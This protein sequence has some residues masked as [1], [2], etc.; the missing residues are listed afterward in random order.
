MTEHVIPQSDY[1]YDIET[2]KHVFMAEFQH[3]ATGQRYV[4]EVSRRRNDTIAFIQFIGF[5][6]E[7]RARTFGYNN[8]E[9]DYVVIH[10]LYEEFQKYGT[11][12]PLAAYD[13]AQEII[14][15]KAHAVAHFLVKQCGY[16]LWSAHDAAIYLLDQDKKQI[17]GIMEQAGYGQ[18]GAQLYTFIDTYE[19]PRFRPKIW[20]DNRLFIQGDLYKIHHFDNKA[21]RT[22]L[23]QL[24]VS[25][26]SRTVVDLPYSPHADLTDEQ[27]DELLQYMGHDV[28]ETIKFYHFSASQIATRDQLAE[29]YP[30]LGDVLNFNDTKIG[31]KFFELELEKASPGICYARDGGRRKPRQT[32]RPTIRLAEIISPKVE[33][34]HPNMRYTLDFFRG[35]ILTSDEVSTEDGGEASAQTKGFF[36]KFDTVVWPDGSTSISDTLTKEQKAEVAERGGKRLSSSTGKGKVSAVMDGF[37]FDFGTGGIHGSLHTTSVYEDDKWEIWDWDVASY[38]PNLAISNRLYPAHLSEKFCEIYEMVYQMRSEYPKKTHPVENGL[39]KLALNG[40][41]GDSNNK[42]SPFYDPQYTMSITINGQLML[43]MLSEWLTQTYMPDGRVVPNGN[44]QMIQANTDGITVKVRKGSVEWMNAVCKHWENHTGLELESVRYS[45]MHLRD[46]NSYMAVKHKD[47]SV[48]RIGAYAYEMPT[49]NPGTRELLW[50]KDHSMRVVTMA[51]EARLVHGTPIAEFIMNHRDPFDFM[52]MM[53]VSKSMRVEERYPDGREQ[54]IQNTGRYYVSTAGAS[55]TK[56][57]PPLKKNP[58]VERPQGIE[59]GWLCKSC[60]DVSD[61]NWHDLNW[62][63]YIKEAEKL[64]SWVN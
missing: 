25:M 43:C 34:R 58:G 45:A 1:G 46:V 39:F 23:K 40:V 59:K 5:L 47:G 36:S 16:D 57:M 35:Q 49:E 8:E 33:L 24:E 30:D 64:T 17:P 11:F 29:K 32:K 7:S 38:Y 61:F 3:I 50:H 37:A 15:P 44:V 6:K 52:K 55:L 51:A 12:T 60:N 4:F 22:S 27:I 56:I 13:K 19:E 42:Y 14:K 18:F 48:K 31:K 10:H 28:S 21:K 41:Y 26:R 9:F 54:R 2:Y 63:Y 20:P 53:K 62:L